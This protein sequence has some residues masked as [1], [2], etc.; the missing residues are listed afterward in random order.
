MGKKTDHPVD[1]ITNFELALEVGHAVPEDLAEGRTHARAKEAAKLAMLANCQRV[2]NSGPTHSM[3]SRF[4]QAVGAYLAED[5]AA[6]FEK[7][8]LKDDPP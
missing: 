3:F 2:V 4:A 8:W 1:R 7:R 6:E 5:L